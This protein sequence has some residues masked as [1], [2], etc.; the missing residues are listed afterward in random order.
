MIPDLKSNPT[1][2][3]IRQAFVGNVKLVELF[4]RTV[5]RARVEKEIRTNER[6]QKI[7]ASD[8]DFWMKRLQ[9]DGV[10][11]SD[12]VAYKNAQ[13]QSAKLAGE[14]YELNKL[15]DIVNLEK[16]E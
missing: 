14:L 4:E 16:Q 3:E 8:I 7:A 2:T 12:G 6:L 15:L 13:E 9:D 10:A 1:W 11:L 5:K